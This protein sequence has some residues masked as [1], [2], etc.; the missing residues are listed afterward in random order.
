MIPLVLLAVGLGGGGYFFLSQEPPTDP[1]APAT[2]TTTALGQIVRL[3]P[4]T[5][6]LSDGR[7]LKVAMALQM[8]EKPQHPELAA[9][10]AGE[11]EG[12]AEAEGGSASPLA[13]EEAK[14]LDSAIAILGDKTYEELSKPGSRQ[15]AKEELSEALVYAYEGDVASVYF[16]T[17]VMA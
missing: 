16:T 3:D 12:A 5:L 2:T 9:I 11:G 15:K 13:G 1:N 17:F 14:A 10:L 8:V 6:N 4:I 7:V